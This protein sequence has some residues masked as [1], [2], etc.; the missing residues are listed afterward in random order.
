MYYICKIINISCSL[1]LQLARPC[2][3]SLILRAN[4][5]NAII[6]SPLR[7]SLR[8]IYYCCHNRLRWHLPSYDNIRH[9]LCDESFLEVPEVLELFLAW[10][11]G[12]TLRYTICNMFSYPLYAILA[13]LCMNH[14]VGS[15]SGIWYLSYDIITPNWNLSC[16]TYFL[17]QNAEVP[18]IAI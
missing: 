10:L 3:W 2:V 9:L 17:I 6:T 4:T 11:D 18:S 5:R 14:Q 16:N 8:F 12:V 13:I 1:M 7:L 15:R